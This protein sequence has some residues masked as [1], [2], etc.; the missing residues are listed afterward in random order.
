MR[1][2]WRNWATALTVYRAITMV[3]EFNKEELRWKLD[4]IVRSRRKLLSLGMLVPSGLF[5][6]ISI[7]LDSP[8]G[9]FD[10]HIVPIFGWLIM[11]ILHGFLAL[12]SSLAA[13]AKEK[14]PDY[15]QRARR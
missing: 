11:L 9:H 3:D 5:F 12:R 1:K 2:I 6:T 10:L 14:F 4:E 7:L 8:F 13:S 15:D